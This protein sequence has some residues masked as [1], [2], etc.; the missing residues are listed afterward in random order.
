MKKVAIEYVD[1]QRAILC[2]TGKMKPFILT[3]ICINIMEHKSW[4]SGLEGIPLPTIRKCHHPE[5]DK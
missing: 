4:S 2:K 1:G 3:D 5:I